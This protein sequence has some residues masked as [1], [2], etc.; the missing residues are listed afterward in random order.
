MTFGARN[1]DR[2][3]DVFYR[4]V[5]GMVG[6]MLLI[7]MKKVFVNHGFAEDKT[8]GKLLMRDNERRSLFVGNDGFFSFTT[9][10]GKGNGGA[11]WLHD[12]I[13]DVSKERLLDAILVLLYGNTEIKRAANTR[14]LRGF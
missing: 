14:P 7:E 3:P 11:C 5:D 9:D 1:I 13:D 4:K 12:H 8:W 10:E 6:S 2:A